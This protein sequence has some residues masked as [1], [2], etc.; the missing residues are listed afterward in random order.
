MKTYKRLLLQL[1]Q[2]DR[3]GP[4]FIYRALSCISGIADQ[5][6]VIAHFSKNHD[7]LTKA[8]EE[9]VAADEQFLVSR[10]ICS[11]ASAR[12]FKTSL[13]E[14]AIDQDVA[15]VVAAGASVDTCFDEEYPELLR[16]IHAPPVVLYRLGE[17]IESNRPALAVVGSREATAYG[18]SCIETFIPPLACAGINLVSGGAVGIDSAVHRKTLENGGITTVLLGSGLLHMYPYANKQLF[19]DVLARGGTIISPFFMRQTPERGTFP[20]RNRIIAGLLVCVWWWRPRLK[21]VR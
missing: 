11:P 6:Q 4:V 19:A 12:L 9:I 17:V 7:A 13:S 5:A 1:L 3:V 10:G 18:F 21:V 14:V 20:A 2:V 16:H 8:L 15:D